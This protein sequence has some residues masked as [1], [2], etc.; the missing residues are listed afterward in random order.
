MFHRRVTALVALVIPFTLLTACTGTIGEIP[1]EANASAPVPAVPGTRA[2]RM[3]VP[4]GTTPAGAPAVGPAAPA[5]P[6][7]PADRCQGAPV[8]S[9]LRRLT[10]FE[11]ANTVQDLLGQT[12]KVIERLPDDVAETMGF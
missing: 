2:D 3:T 12:F 5:A 11:Y 7:A 1:G 6:A 10:S 8:A 4:G 9:T